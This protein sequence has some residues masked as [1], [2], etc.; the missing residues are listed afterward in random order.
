[1]SL[2]TAPQAAIGA[3]AREIV[4]VDDNEER[5]EILAALLEREGLTVHS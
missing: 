2:A 4:I 1:M 5:R 3:P